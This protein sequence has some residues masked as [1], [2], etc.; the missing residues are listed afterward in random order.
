MDSSNTHPIF[1]LKIF[2]TRIYVVRSPEYVSLTL[3]ESKTLTF[4]PFTTA[5]L[6]YAL[7]GPPSVVEIFETTAYLSEMHTQMYSALSIGPD[8]L[9]SNSRVLNALSRYLIP[10]ETNLYAFLREAYTIAS[11]E[12]FY[13]PDNPVPGLIDEIWYIFSSFAITHSDFIGNLKII[14][15]F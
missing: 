8:L 10:Q 1:T 2:N 11:G 12:T 6:K 9:E 4:E 14:S 3:R 15:D 5:F 7:N 13:G